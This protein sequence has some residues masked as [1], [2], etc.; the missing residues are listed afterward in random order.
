MGEC[1]CTSND[2]RYKFP[3]PGK[4]FYI[5]TLSGGCLSC[6]APPG[7]SIEHI[8][9][10]THLHEYYSERDYYDG[11]LKF[12]KWSDSEGVGIVTGM[13]RQEFVAATQ[14]HLIGV[15]SKDLGEDGAFDEMGAEVLLDEMYEDATAR[16][17]LVT[18]QLK[19]QSNAL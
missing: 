1:G 15:N 11:P 19:E 18:P 4:S 17:K 6:D 9:P 13:T 5:L 3:G 16:P 12:E 7:V 8:K 14:K 2:E 10:G